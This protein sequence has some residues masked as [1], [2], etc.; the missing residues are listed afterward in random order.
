M[1]VQGTS[2]SKQ[3]FRVLC[4][5]FAIVVLTNFA[6]VKLCGRSSQCSDFFAFDV[7]ATSV[8]MPSPRAVQTTLHQSRAVQTT[9]HQ[10]RA[11]QTTLHQSR[12]LTTANDVG[13]T[14][15][16]T[17]T[18]AS[19]SFGVN[20]TNSMNVSVGEFGVYMVILRN[21][22]C[23]P[24]QPTTLVVNSFTLYIR[25][26]SY[27]CVNAVGVLCAYEYRL[28]SFHNAPC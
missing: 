25:M 20:A 24:A 9:L 18:N 10:S 15:A 22:L 26:M 11:V 23:S 7:V 13:V 27:P 28:I 17:D 5:T 2:S 1:S 3:V 16:S 19:A 8:H 12:A 21:Q 4:L 14:A 6:F